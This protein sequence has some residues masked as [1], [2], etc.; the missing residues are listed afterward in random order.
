M[1][2]KAVARNSSTGGSA[3]GRYD[4]IV[5]GGRVAGA[6][7]AMLLARG[8][9]RVL[10]LERAPVAGTDTLSTFALMRAG[11]LQL[12]RWGLLDRVVAAGTPPVRRT[13][14]HYGDEAVTVPI[15]EK[16]GV[17]ELFAPRR[18]VLDPI[19]VDAAVEAGAEVRYG[20]AVKGLL[21]EG[22]RVTG[23][24]GVRHGGV[25]FEA[26]APLVI[27]ADGRHSVVAREVDPPATWRGDASGGAVYGFWAGLDQDGYEWFY[28]PGLGGGIIP[29]NEGLACV[30][31]SAA[32]PR[33]VEEIRHDVEGGFHRLLRQ[34]APEAADRAARGA[35]VGQLRGFP[36]V[37]GYL[38]KPWGPGWALVGDAGSFR[39]PISAHGISDALRD[40]EFLARAVPAA[41]QDPSAHAA[42][43]AGYERRRDDVARPLAEVTDAVAAYA[44]TLPELKE[45]LLALS[46]TMS[47]EVEILDAL[48]PVPAMAA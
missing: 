35:Q 33:L 47:R 21:R 45:M 41:L 4:V 44:W 8:G 36:G 1:K 13:V 10:V 48:T 24:Y 39:D 16:G 5:V 7:T 29:T 22:N 38:R 14:L 17:T 11:V 27:G 42:A 15:K 34:V 20:A 30:W 31:V 19:L 25:V 12:R 3:A 40:A 37:S 32:T 6:S 9:L 28:R 46:K 26:R 43:M 2:T 18:T 23:V